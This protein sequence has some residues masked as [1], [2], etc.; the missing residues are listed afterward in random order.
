MRNRFI[1]G[2]DQRKLSNNLR[3]EKDS[4]NKY[5][6]KH[7]CRKMTCIIHHLKFINIIKLINDKRKQKESIFLS[8]VVNI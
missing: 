3:I 2:W 8:V 6:K 5:L 1:I 4:S 7:F